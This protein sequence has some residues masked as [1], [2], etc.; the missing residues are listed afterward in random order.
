MDLILTRNEF[1]ESGIF[2]NL[3]DI[4]GNIV[5]YSLE[6]SYDSGLGN[7]S[8]A[9]K[10]PDGE[11]TCQRGEHRLAHMTQP[12]TTFEIQNVPRHTNILFHVGNFNDDSEGCVLL[13]S[14]INESGH[15]LQDS[16]VA[17]DK[18]MALQNDIQTFKLTVRS[19]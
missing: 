11:Y 4:D 5:T 9:P 17:F 2:G 3:S 8:Y 10:L 7:G 15:F 16:R 14:S 13:G 12:F 18:F 1:L 6:H 19:T